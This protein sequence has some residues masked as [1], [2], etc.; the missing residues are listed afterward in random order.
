MNQYFDLNELAALTDAETLYENAPCGYL[1]FVPDGT[2]FR[3]NKTLLLWLQLT[4]DEVVHRL[5][6]PELICKG[7]NIHF[8]MFFRPMI[9]VYGGVK[10]LRYELMKKDGSALT[11][12]ISANAVKKE[13]GKIAAINAAVYEITDRKKY[14]HEL[15]LA[16]GKAETERKRFTFLADQT[17]DIIWTAA[18]NG[19][20]DYVNAQFFRYWGIKKKN[21]S[22]ASILTKVHPEDRKKLVKSWVNC[23]R[24]TDELKCDIRV[25]DT[26]NK[27]RWHLVRARPNFNEDG[28]LS[29][30][31]GTCTDIDEHINA[32]KRKDEFI[33][34]ASHELKTP[35]TSLKATL[36]FLDRMKNNPQPT[37]PLLVEQANRSMEKITYLIDDLLNVSRI[38]EGDIQLNRTPFTIEEFWASCIPSIDLHNRF[39]LIIQGNMKSRVSADI[40]KLEQVVVN[41]INNAVK[42]APQSKQ[43]HVI[44]EEE[45]RNVKISVKDQGPGIAPDEMPHL[46]ERYF[47]IEKSSSHYSGL[48]LGLYICA[49]IVKRHGGKIG[50]QS[51]LGQGSTFWF[52]LPRI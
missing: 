44:V 8:E 40:N 36:Q 12:L 5:K 1:S 35:V 42:Y 2:I 26:K 11:V 10:E 47:R 16:K 22:R 46:F 6:F 9:N 30:W 39:E 51:E 27:Y 45:G 21:L 17:P 23:L 3:I 13:N 28:Q 24:T 34:I 52:T 20:I 32:L 41:L 43:I 15:L 25:L 18:T 31:F 38:H 33:N 14:E 50:V 37:L 7:G 29:N 4:A 49:D 48:G 19:K